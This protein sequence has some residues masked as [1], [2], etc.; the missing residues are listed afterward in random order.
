MDKLYTV[1]EIA[2]L[3]DVSKPTVQIAINAAAIEA[4][5]EDISLENGLSFSIEEAGTLTPIDANYRGFY[6]IYN[7]TSRL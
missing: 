5:K 6:N 3:L 2:E 4:D 7:K 1:K